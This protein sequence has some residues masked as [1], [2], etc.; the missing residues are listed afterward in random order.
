MEK[1]SINNE[2]ILVSDD[3]RVWHRLDRNGLVIYENVVPDESTFH[4]AMGKL[5]NR[6]HFFKPA[7]IDAEKDDVKIYQAETHHDGI[8]YTLTAYVFKK[9]KTV[10]NWETMTEEEADGSFSDI[11]IECKTKTDENYHFSKTFVAEDYHTDCIPQDTIIRL[12]KNYGLA[13]FVDYYMGFPEKE[14]V[15]FWHEIDR[16]IDETFKERTSND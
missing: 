8:E 4:K 11:V 5:Y 9:N 3:G 13:P 14:K 1:W 16:Q 10:F 15:E 7:N 6:F 12:F 2:T